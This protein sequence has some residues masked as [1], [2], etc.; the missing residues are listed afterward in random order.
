MQSVNSLI[1]EKSDRY[2]SVVLSPV[3]PDEAESVLLRGLGHLR[4]RLQHFRPE[5]RL[6]VEYL[7][8]INVLRY[9]GLFV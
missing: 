9:Y 6:V 8:N 2:K 3:C 7:T 4:H 5:H 1:D